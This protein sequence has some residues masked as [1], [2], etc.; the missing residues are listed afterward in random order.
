MT[1]ADFKH[2]KHSAKRCVEEN[3][4]LHEVIAA[5]N[6]PHNQSRSKYNGDISHFVHVAGVEYRVVTTP[7]AAIRTVTRVRPGGVVRR[8]RHARLPHGGRRRRR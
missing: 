4:G 6:V 7:D 2:T 5:L 3:V 8:M 1:W